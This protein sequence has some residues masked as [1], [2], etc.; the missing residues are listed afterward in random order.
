M[1]PEEEREYREI[2]I[3]AI[4]KEEQRRAMIFVDAAQQA[5]LEAFG[6]EESARILRTYAQHIED[7]G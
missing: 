2:E 5:L 6:A 1:T 3:E 7:Y 4:L